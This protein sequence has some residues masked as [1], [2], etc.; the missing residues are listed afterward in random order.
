MKEGRSYSITFKPINPCFPGRANLSRRYQ[1]HGY[2]SI[3]RSRSERPGTDHRSCHQRQ[4]TIPSP[5]RTGSFPS[6]TFPLGAYKITVT[7]AGFATYTADNVD[8]TAGSTYTSAVRLSSGKGEPIGRG[9][10]RC[11]H[12]RYYDCDTERH[13]SGR[14]RAEHAAERTGLYP[15]DRDRAG[16][17]RL[18]NQRRRHDQ[19]GSQQRRQLATRRHR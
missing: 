13:Y 8:L 15:A 11:A 6:R 2:G 10:R 3:R 1:R 19:R 12:H 18:L 5:L 7:V 16:L 9:A 4:T 17:R 14:S